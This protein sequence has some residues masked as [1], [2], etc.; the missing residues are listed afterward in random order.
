MGR[1]RKK[2]TDAD[3]RRACDKFLAQRET[4]HVNFRDQIK[5]DADRER[6]L[7]LRRKQDKIDRIV[8]SIERESRGS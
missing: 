8:D 2:I 3:F 1:R 6:Q 5:T 4:G 7:R